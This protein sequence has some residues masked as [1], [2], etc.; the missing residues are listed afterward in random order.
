LAFG[1]CMM[2]A[3]NELELKPIRKID[4]PKRPRVNAERVI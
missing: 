3:K 2:T 4:I 1:V